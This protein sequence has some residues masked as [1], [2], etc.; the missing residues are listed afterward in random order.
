MAAKK[1]PDVKPDVQ[2]DEAQ[3]PDVDVF[4]DI[5]KLGL[6]ASEIAPSEKVLT[7]LDVR[8]PKRDEFV[9]CHPTLAARINIYED[10]ETRAVYLIGPSVLGRM[11]ELVQG[12]VKPV[13]LTLTANYGGGVFAW[14]VPVPAD[15]RANQWHAT[16][17]HAA[18]EA[19]KHWIRLVAGNGQYDVFRRTVNEGVMPVWPE[20]ADT[21]EKMLR[22]AFAKVGG[23]ELINDPEHPI[24]LALEGRA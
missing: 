2:D 21:V 16:A 4:S 14:P 20:E 15:V 11:A 6:S 17:F 5:A 18:E 24:V 19:A 22:M 13:T 7:V 12:G 10:G 9:R 23:A 3:A 1:Q 8:K